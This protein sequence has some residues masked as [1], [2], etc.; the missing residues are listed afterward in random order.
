MTEDLTDFDRTDRPGEGS[1]DD[2]A[3]IKRESHCFQP[4]YV[5]YDSDGSQLARTQTRQEA[6]LWARQNDLVP[7][8]VH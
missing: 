2:R 6:I 1:L 7:S 8:D 3:Y 5:I 4:I